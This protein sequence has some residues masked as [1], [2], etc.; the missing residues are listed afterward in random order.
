MH[1]I[2]YLL[3]DEFQIMAVAT[4]AVFEYANMVTGEPFYQVE[5]FSLAGNEVRSS[6]GL[7][8][9]TR[10]PTARTQV[11]TWIISGVGDPLRFPASAEEQAFLKK[12]AT[13]ARRVAAICTGGFVLAESGL[14]AGRRATT[15]WYFA[16]EMQKRFPDIQV[17]DDRIYIVDGPIW[18]SAGM[19]AGLDLALA[20]VEKDLGSDA[21]RSVAHKLV[22]H[23]RRSGG[24]SQH[25]EILDLS[26]KSDRIQN[27][28]NYARKN[29]SKELTVDELAESVNLS[30]RQ[31]SRVFTEE[32]GQSPAKA[33]E[34]LRL[35]A[36]RLMI[37]QS[38]HPLEVIARETGFR[39][40]RHM[41]EVFM[42]GFGVPPQA[43]RR[44]VR[45][46]REAR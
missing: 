11:D 34:G 39:D 44:E 32:T 37:E 23:Q 5:N 1:R 41:R 45:E 30:P 43:I 18:T 33:I 28:L 2:G 13:R 4:Q 25:S 17:E 38:R 35:E 22:M 14:L 42:R 7:R 9:E 24:Q 31:F 46:V 40:R 15:H 12:A 3:Q 20:M 16:R 6:L 27:A 8:V 21:M 29:L 36:A 19:T 10:V 26:P